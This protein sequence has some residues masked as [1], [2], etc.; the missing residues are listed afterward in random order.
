[1]LKKYLKKLRRKGLKKQKLLVYKLYVSLNQNYLLSKKSK[2]SRMGK[3]KGAF[4]REAI[5]VKKFRP[6]IY[7]S[8]YKPQTLSKL[9]KR[10]TEKTNKKLTCYSKV[11]SERIYSWTKNAYTYQ[12]VKPFLLV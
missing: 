7:S 6:F 8:G 4:I 1:M 3:G 10:F 11:G 2:N 5:K 9:A 12:Y